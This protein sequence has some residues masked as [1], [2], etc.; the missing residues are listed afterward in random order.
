MIDTE[1]SDPTEELA[2]PLRQEL[3][4]CRQT[5]AGLQEDLRAAGSEL[6][7]LRNEVNT[8]KRY[9]IVFRWRKFLSPRIQAEAQYP[10]HAIYIPR[11]YARL[12]KLPAA[13]P[14]IAIVTP[15]YKQGHFVERTLRSV[16]N[17]DYPR[18]HYAVQDGGSQDG[19]VDLLK[20]YQSRLAAWD[21][22]PDHGQ[23]HAINVGFG[24]VQGDIMAY[25]NSDDLLLP[26]S[27]HYVADWFARHPDVEV[28]YSHRVMI[29]GDD[30]EV[31]RWILPRHD[32]QTLGWVDYVP[33]ET[34][35]WRRSIWEKTGAAMDESFQFALDWDLLLRFRAAGARMV[36]VPRFLGAFR[37]HQSQKTATQMATRGEAEIQSLRTRTHGRQ[38]LVSEIG[39]AIKKWMRRQVLYRHL[40][41]FG[42]LRH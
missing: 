9:S 38:V 30:N 32:E 18:L 24:K 4:S 2:T 3:A 37:L 11:W 14:R 29:D 1:I 19:T 17:Q 21:S 15:S 7:R 10:P 25:L 8:L 13:P 42:L 6:Q 27:L 41:R 16:L 31:G 26:G 34:L 36:R 23:A 20:R 28:I 12:P 40:Y 5:I 39:P 33:Q 22:R 35:F